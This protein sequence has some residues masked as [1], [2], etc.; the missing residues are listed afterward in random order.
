MAHTGPLAFLTFSLLAIDSYQFSCSRQPSSPKFNCTA[1]LSFPV[2]VQPLTEGLTKSSSTTGSGCWGTWATG[3]TGYAPEPMADSQAEREGILA[4]PLILE[5]QRMFPKH[6]KLGLQENLHLFSL[7]PENYLFISNK[8]LKNWSI[9]YKEKDQTTFHLNYCT[10]IPSNLLE[11][12]ERKIST[13]RIWIMP[14]SKGYYVNSTYPSTSELQ[15]SHRYKVSRILSVN[16]SGCPH[17][18]LA[19]HTHLRSKP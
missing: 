5:K 13:K 14:A 7:T 8:D 11:L 2:S 19:L 10:N 9:N 17:L 1:Y 6:W 16:T 3:H 18:F 4:L 15:G 12:H